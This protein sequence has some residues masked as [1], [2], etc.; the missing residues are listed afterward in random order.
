MS[1]YDLIVIENT[2]NGGHVAEYRQCF[3]PSSSTIRS[4]ECGWW[5]LGEIHPEEKSKS[6]RV[7]PQEWAYNPQINII[8]WTLSFIPETASMDSL[9]DAV[10]EDRNTSEHPSLP[11]A[12]STE[13]QSLEAWDVMDNRHFML[14]LRV[15]EL[16]VPVSALSRMTLHMI[17]EMYH[18]M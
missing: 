5:Q 11:A 18:P 14:M 12:R 4:G 1:M 2:K 8:N 9:K 10:S 16:F 7:I 13:Y 17:D 6:D 15:V 3:L